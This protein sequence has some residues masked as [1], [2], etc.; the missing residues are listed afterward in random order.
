M[1]VAIGSGIDAAPV[2]KAVNYYS[3][4][5]CTSAVNQFSLSAR[6][7]CPDISTCRAEDW[8]GYARS[9][10]MCVSNTAAH[11]QMMF[12][13]DAYLLVTHYLDSSCKIE[14]Y[15]HGVRLLQRQCVATGSAT[16]VR[17][18]VRV[19]WSVDILKYSTVNCAGSVTY[20]DRLSPSDVSSGK[21]YNG[22]KV[23]IVQAPRWS[24]QSYTAIIIY[25]D[26]TCTTAAYIWFRPVTVETVLTDVVSSPCQ[27][28]VSGIYVSR[29]PFVDDITTFV[30][31]AFGYDVPYMIHDSFYDAYCVYD[32]GVE[33]FRA[34][35]GCYDTGA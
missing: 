2:Y 32:F 13:N 35:G 29:D 7:A 16:S 25:N 21:C 28:D 5:T 30:G 19:D 1:A 4:T 24:P 14:N 23:N 15:I 11:A 9:S 12:G 22:L 27:R 31:G 20:I 8:N 3:D 17:Y 18:T 26:A 6:N 33:A 10:V 34:D